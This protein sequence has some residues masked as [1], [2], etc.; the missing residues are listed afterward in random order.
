MAGPCLTIYVPDA[1]SDL[2]RAEIENYIEVIS[3]EVQGNDFWVS[4]Q[5]FLWNTHAPDEE[6]SLLDLNGWGPKLVMYFCAMC[7]NPASHVLLA[8]ICDKVASMINGM[9]LLGD[10]TYLT[11]NPMVLKMSGHIIVEDFGYIVEP[12]FLSYWLGE[13]EFRLIK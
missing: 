6:E 2:N 3:N 9:I 4:G 7:N 5:P 11:D 13:R 1:L 10:M 12:K 8:T